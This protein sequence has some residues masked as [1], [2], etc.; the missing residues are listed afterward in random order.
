MSIRSGPNCVLDAQDTDVDEFRPWGAWTGVPSYPLFLN[1]P[2]AIKSILTFSSPQKKPQKTTAD[3]YVPP[4][5]IS[6]D[7]F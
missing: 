5:T 2:A 6:E 3:I 4:W 1:L 7:D